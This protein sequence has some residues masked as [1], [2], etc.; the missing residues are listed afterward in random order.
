MGYCLI[1]GG[2]TDGRYDIELDFGKAQKNAI[3]AALN[4]AI[5]KNDLQLLQTENE[6]AE[7]QAKE[8]ALGLV[9]LQLQD[10]I[11]TGTTAD[12]AQATVEYPKRAAE[13]AKLKAQNEPLRYKLRQLKFVRVSLRKQAQTFNLFQPIERRQAWCTDLTEDRA[14]GAYVGTLEVKGEPDLVLIQPGARAWIPADG[15]VRGREVMSPWQAYWNA[16]VMPGWQKWKPTYRWGT[17][18]SINYNNDTCSVSL[19]AATSSAQRLGINQASTLDNVPISYMTCNAQAFEEGDRVIVRFSGQ[20]WAAPLVVGFLDNPKGCE[21]WQYVAGGYIDAVVAGPPRYILACFRHL[22]TETQFLADLNA[23]TSYAMELRVNGGAWLA[24]TLQEPWHPGGNHWRHP[25]Y[26]PLEVA[27]L[28]SRTPIYDAS[29]FLLAPGYPA[30]I[31]L[32]SFINSGW[33]PGVPDHPPFALDAILE[34]RFTVDGE[35]YANFAVRAGF[36]PVTVDSNYKIATAAPGVQL[37]G[38]TLFIEE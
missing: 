17:I 19:A 13:L 31:R 3:M 30:H 1:T 34:V 16:A 29:F 20:D 35:V 36:A 33:A 6:L 28:S 24:L 25:T 21:G 4:A 37:E 18:S 32:A 5:N 8:Q 27:L 15:I 23:A 7:A 2:G 10:T 11:A 38:Y 9:L 26:Y 22:K 12:K 14:A